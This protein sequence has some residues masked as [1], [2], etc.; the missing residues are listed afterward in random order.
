MKLK[1]SNLGGYDI[2]DESYFGSVVD[3]SVVAP[4]RNQKKNQKK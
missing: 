3:G 4:A 2:D 1:G